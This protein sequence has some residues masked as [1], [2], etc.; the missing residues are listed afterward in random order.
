M[1]KLIEILSHFRG[2]N[3]FAQVSIDFIWP[4]EWKS[5]NR[6]I[7]LRNDHN[8]QYA[9]GFHLA[10]Y[11]CWAGGDR[12]CEE[13]VIQ[14]YIPGCD[15]ASYWVTEMLKNAYKDFRFSRRHNPLII[16]RLEVAWGDEWDDYANAE[17][18]FESQGRMGRSL[19]WSFVCYNTTS[20]KA[21]RRFSPI[22]ILYKFSPRFLHHKKKTTK[23]ELM[24]EE[25]L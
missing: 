9:I 10:R 21:F 14:V 20:Q 15:K 22:E 4:W 17:E 7:L 13:T 5:G 6:Y 18:D 8:T 11:L 23:R 19:G 12:S 25:A 24:T 1:K 3:P 16:H 2:L